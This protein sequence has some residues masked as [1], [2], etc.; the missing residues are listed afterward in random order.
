MPVGSSPRASRIRTHPTFGEKA[1]AFSALV[2]CLAAGCSVGTGAGSAT[3][4]INV[5]QCELENSSYSLDPTFWAGE[6]VVDDQLELRMQRS[7]A[8]ESASDGVRLLVQD[9][10]RIKQE[11]LGVPLDLSELTPMVSMS[12]YLNDTCPVEFDRIPV[13]YESVSG[14]VTFQAMYAPELDD[15]DLRI[16]ASWTGVRLEADARSGDH[17]AEIDGALNFV[18][19]RG[20]PAQRYP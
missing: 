4:V 10:T 12:L 20:R 3:G 1:S 5:P 14:T 6:F 9:P 17:Y 16:T 8:I 7:G 15:D 19:N 13:N 11:L 18:F 2:L